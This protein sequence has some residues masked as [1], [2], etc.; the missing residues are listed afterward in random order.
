VLKPVFIS[1]KD[2]IDTIIQKYKDRAKVYKIIDYLD[3][4]EKKELV[5]AGEVKTIDKKINAFYTSV[6]SSIEGYMYKKYIMEREKYHIIDKEKTQFFDSLVKLIKIDK[7]KNENKWEKANTVVYECINS[8]F[9]GGELERIN[10][11]YDSYI[12]FLSGKNNKNITANI[13]AIYTSLEKFFNK[14]D[15]VKRTRLKKNKK[16]RETVYRILKKLIEDGRFVELLE[17]SFGFKCR[18]GG[19]ESDDDILARDRFDEYKLASMTDNNQLLSKIGFPTE[20]GYYLRPAICK[21]DAEDFKAIK[22]ITTRL[23]RI[24]SGLQDKLMKHAK[25]L[26]EFMIKFWIVKPKG[27][28]T[29]TFRKDIFI[30]QL[31]KEEYAKINDKFG[32]Y[33]ELLPNGQAQLLDKVK[34]DTGGKMKQVKNDIWKKLYGG[35]K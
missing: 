15:T 34:Y 20:A 14:K 12:S 21:Q 3:A 26:T 10:E 25:T 24:E 35:K 28:D 13:H 29:Y 16:D 32:K 9:S 2:D 19:A 5:L 11:V 22:K 31:S 6:S 7:T 18:Q 8:H 23:I 27:E 4:T 30:L 17:K 1:L 33:Y